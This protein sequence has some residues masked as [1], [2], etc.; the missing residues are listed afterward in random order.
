MLAPA[1]AMHGVQESVYKSQCQCTRVSVQESVSVYKSQCTRVS[2]L[3]SVS[4]Y[5]SQCQCTRVSVS[6]QV[7][8]YKSQL[9]NSLHQFGCVLNTCCYLVIT[10]C[11]YSSDNPFTLF[12]NANPLRSLDCKRHADTQRNSIT[13]SL[14]YTSCGPQWCLTRASAKL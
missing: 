13:E 6:V 4:V 1:I 10:L 8:V 14:S 2:V 12:V 9:K 5:K 7:S 3:E 11:T